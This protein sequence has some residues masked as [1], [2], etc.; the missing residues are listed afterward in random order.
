MEE[1]K[2]QPTPTPVPTTQPTDPSK[3]TDPSQGTQ[4]TDPKPTNPKP[5]NPPSG[6]HVC[7]FDTVTISLSEIKIGDKGN[8]DPN[9]ILRI[10]SSEQYVHHNNCTSL[11]QP[12]YSTV[13]GV[14][15]QALPGTYQ[16]KWTGNCGEYYQTVIITE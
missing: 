11:L 1:K 15:S 9:V 2:N 3:P 12:V 6:D 8:T 16:V 7:Y 4:T 5:T 13:P 10:I 14:S